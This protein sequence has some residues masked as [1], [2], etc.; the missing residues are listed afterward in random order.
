MRRAFA[1]VAAAS[2][3]CLAEKADE[4]L[5]D[6]DLSSLSKP[7]LWEPTLEEY[8]PAQRGAAVERDENGLPS[9]VV[10]KSPTR[11][12]FAYHARRGYPIIVSDWGKGMKYDGWS[13]KDFAKAY[14]FGWMK[15]EYIDDMP[16]FKRK[17]HEI[18]MIDGEKRFKLGS[19]K[20]DGKTPWYNFSRPASKR[21]KDDP[22]KP[23]TGPYVWHVKDE[24]PPNEKKQVQ[25]KFEAP[26]FLQ[27]PLNRNKMNNSFEL[28]FSP[29]NGAGAGAHNDGYCQS[30]VSLQLVGDKKWRKQLEP[31]LT[32]LHSY[33]EFDGGVYTAG[34]WKPDLG[35]LN[36]QGGAVIWPPGY[37]HETKTT[38]PPNGDCGA[39]I[40]LQYSFPQPVQFLRAFLP[41]LSL[42]SEVG[43]CLR[44][45]WS[46]YPTFFHKGMNPTRK[47][48]A[49]KEQLQKILSSVDSDGDERITVAE[50]LAWL[51]KPDSVAARFMRDG[52]AHADLYYQFQAEDTVAYSDLDNDM[53][54]T[55]DE[56]WA[57]LVQWNVVSMRIKMGLNYVNTA[58][59]EGLEKFEKSLDHMRRQPVQLPKKLRPELAQLFRLPKGT[60]IFKNLKGINSFSDQEFFSRVHE[61]LETLSRKHGVEL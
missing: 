4:P 1:V 10:L 19:F 56:L 52:P 38:Q 35:F 31:D 6:I 11:E 59:R 5:F 24:L 45:E 30:V 32:F 7:P 28:W 20:P 42:S 8:F 33:D 22:L 48:A 57:A 12:E 15:A 34:Y 26:P 47:E 50:T 43:H 13:G 21:Y 60:K 46:V 25:S 16:G 54:V 58:D 9:P 55:R 18:R 39:A 37:L 14:P 41:R 27:D 36:T 40:T 61:R 53:V 23:I 2:P 17:D 3:V 49:M 44:N 29:G 51:K